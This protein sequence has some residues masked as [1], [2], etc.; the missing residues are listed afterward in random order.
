MQHLSVLIPF[1]AAA[2]PRYGAASPYCLLHEL[3]CGGG[4]TGAVV[5]GAVLPALQRAESQALHHIWQNGVSVLVDHH[6]ETSPRDAGL[7][8][9]H[10]RLTHGNVWRASSDYEKLFAGTFHFV[11][12]SHALHGIQTYMSPYDLFH[13]HL[14]RGKVGDFATL[15]VLF[16]CAEY[17]AYGSGIFDFHLGHC[18]VG[19]DCTPSLQAWRYRNV[20]WSSWWPLESAAR[21]IGIT[22][23]VAEQALWLLDGMANAVADLRVDA[24]PFGPKCPNTVWEGNFGCRIADIYHLGGD[25]V[26]CGDLAYG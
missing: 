9:G 26:W 4:Q 14:V 25:I 22:Q 1:C 13:G 3:I 7:V 2:A 11:V 24:T 17:P 15:N 5:R 21:Q 20:L 19:S 8:F 10:C 16:H 12:E 23:P 6:S 18:Q